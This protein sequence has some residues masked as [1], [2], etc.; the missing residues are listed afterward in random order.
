MSSASDVTHTC[1]CP[2]PSLQQRAV[3]GRDTNIECG[4]V[5]EMDHL[6]TGGL[7]HRR[8]WPRGRAPP[9]SMRSTS[10]GTLG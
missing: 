4:M 10:R 1:N 6:P 3:C 5:M 2:L 8:T 9:R 7:L